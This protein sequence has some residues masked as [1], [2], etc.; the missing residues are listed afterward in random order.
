M[1]EWLPIVNV[2]IVNNKKKNTHKA[3]VLMNNY[4]KEPLMENHNN[5]IIDC[6]NASK[7]SWKSLK[8][9]IDQINFCVCA[10]SVNWQTSIWTRQ[11]KTIFSVALCLLSSETFYKFCSFSAL[12]CI[13]LQLSVNLCSGTIDALRCDFFHMNINWTHCICFLRYIRWVKKSLVSANSFVCLCKK[14]E[15]ELK[16]CNYLYKIETH[17]IQKTRQISKPKK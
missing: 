11:N 17:W 3:F 4:R 5:L 16:W 12:S 8:N 6:L 2:L 14:N 1:T 10:R 13:L 15:P 7:Q 9:K